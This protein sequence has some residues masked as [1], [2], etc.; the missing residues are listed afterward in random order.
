MFEG[1]SW[2]VAAGESWAVIGPSGCGK[3]TL[4][5]LVAG[6]RRP[7]EGRVLVR[8]REASARENRGRIGLV[9][10]DYGLL[11]WSTV[12]DNARLGL[13]LRRLYGMSC[14]GSQDR[15]RSW[16]QRLGIEQ[17]TGKFP[18]QLSGGERQRVAIARALALEPD[19]LLL[20]EPFASLDALTRESLERLSVSLWAETGMTTV[21][22][23]HNIEEAVFVGR[24]I[25]V[26]GALPNREPVV[27]DNSLAGLPRKARGDDFVGKCS[28]LRAALGRERRD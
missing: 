25:L 6:L 22:V 13:R 17:L 11:P 27:L 15:L 3:T 23:T 28:E 18:S 1:F 5:Y 4:L 19:V 12:W 21:I 20:D 26:L 10:Q 8:G 24:R 14:N 2:V 16:L 7:T 9:L